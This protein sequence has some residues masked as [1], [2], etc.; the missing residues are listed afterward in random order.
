MIQ[1]QAK[2]VDIQ[3]SANKL[4]A[5]ITFVPEQIFEFHGWQFAFIEIPDIQDAD[6][7][8]LKRAYSIWSS[9]AQLQTQWTFTTLVKKTRNGGMSDYLT[10][11]L[12]V[13]DSIKCTAPLGHLGK[14]SKSDTYLLISTGSWLTPIYSMYQTLITSWQYTKIAHIFGERQQ[15]NLIDSIINARQETDTIR[16]YLHLS[17]DTKT[18]RQPWH[19]QASLDKALAFLDTSNIQVYICGKPTMVEDIVEQ[20]VQKWISP[21]NIAFEKY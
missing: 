21:D 5:Y 9:N 1:T 18:G 15:E 10:N 7:K 16:H 17:Q 13:G 3:Y 19:I 20:L 12:Q 4:V 11:K 8:A 14:E 6:G 2:V